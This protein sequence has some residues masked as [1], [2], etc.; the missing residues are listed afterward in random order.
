MLTLILVLSGG[1]CWSDGLVRFLNA[2]IPAILSM[3]CIFRVIVLEINNNNVF[4]F[5]SYMYIMLNNT[6]YYLKIKLDIPAWLLLNYIFLNIE[7]V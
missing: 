2:Y 3:V 7:L 4:Y 1:Q 6:I 5:S